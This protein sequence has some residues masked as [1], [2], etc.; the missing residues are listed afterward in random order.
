MTSAG[1]IGNKIVIANVTILFPKMEKIG[2]GCLYNEG[3]VHYE[4]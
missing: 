2:L 4:R 1:K 3:G